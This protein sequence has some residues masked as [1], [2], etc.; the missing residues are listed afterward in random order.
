MAF[1]VSIL[2]T[3]SGQSSA[4]FGTGTY[5]TASFTPSNNCRLW[6]LIEGTEESD[7]GLEGTTFTI[8]GGGLT[9]NS[10]DA[11]TTSPSWSYGQAL[12]YADVTTA[13]SMAVS[14]DAGAFN[15]H[16]YRVTVFQVIDGDV[17]GTP[18]V[19]TKQTG[20]TNDGALAVTLSG[21]P[22]S[23]SYLAAALYLS[24]SGATS[25]NVDPGTT[26]GSW[27]EDHDETEPGWQTF[28]METISSGYTGTTADWADI[29][30]SGIGSA[31]VGYS[32]FI[33]EFRANAGARTMAADPGAFTLTGRE[34]SMTEYP[35]S[36]TG[37]LV[38]GSAASWVGSS[39][40]GAS[41]A[42]GGSGSYTLTATHGTFTL[43]GQAV[44][45]TST[46]PLTASNGVYTLSGQAVTLRRGRPMVA[47]AG[48]YTLTGSDAAID[49]QVAVSAGAY[50]LTGQAVTLTYTPAGDPVMTA[51]AGSL[52]LTGQAVGLRHGYALPSSAGSFAITG[53]AAALRHA[54][55]L[56]ASAGS[57]ALSGQ[58]VGLRRGYPLVS[59]AGAF[60]LT[61]Q[62]A[63]LTYTPAGADPSM[64][65]DAGVYTL[66]GQA[67]GLRVARNLACAA[68]S[69]TLSGQIA[70]LLVG[71]VLPIAAGAYT[72]TGQDVTFT[73]AVAARL[74]AEPGTLSFSGSDASFT[75]PSVSRTGGDDAPA[76]GKKRHRGWNAKRD[77][78]KRSEEQRLTANI[79][80][81]Y[82]ELT[83]DPTTQAAAEEIVAPLVPEAAAP[84]DTT[85]ARSARVQ[86]L[87]AELLTIEA[88]I[89]LRLLAKQKR[90][91]DE[92]AEDIEAITSL[93]GEF[94]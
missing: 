94:F 77:E 2:A 45:L 13:S 54:Y 69:F 93:L 15:V 18:V 79:R 3:P 62:A 7:T 39:Y 81:L 60:T 6:V 44:T 37:G 88:E 38:I 29:N 75:A 50:T 43:S 76:G 68:G 5:T 31:I 64:T 49:I 52:T 91:R 83:D 80:A 47:T 55:V 36:N 48:T 92:E 70:G 66:T 28:S 58:A 16:R 21:T 11:T 46:A 74:T 14:V 89:A 25:V 71:R 61:G 10:Q 84:A 30:T 59:S 24:L 63:T 86:A 90:E 4:T 40:V 65:A 9:W 23:T 12:H 41:D 17:A 53:Q 67:T 20:T 22:L 72:L 78:L 27:T 51:S 56:G 8:S 35:S 1:S 85:V 82:R 34:M 42:T 87:R 33:I 57:F 73:A 26:P 19:V 32:A